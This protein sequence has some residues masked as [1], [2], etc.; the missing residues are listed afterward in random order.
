MQIFKNRTSRRCHRKNER[1]SS[2]YEDNDHAIH[3]FPEHDSNASIE[4]GMVP[5]AI[6]AMLSS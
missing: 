4:Q 6:E 5:S 3:S 1:R 2:G